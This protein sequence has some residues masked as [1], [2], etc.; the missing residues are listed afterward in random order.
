[1]ERRAGDGRPSGFRDGGVVHDRE[2]RPFKQ[3]LITSPPPSSRPQQR[4]DSSFA[5]STLVKY[6]GSFGARSSFGLKAQLVPALIGLGCRGT[7]VLELM[8]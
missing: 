4:A 1:M 2:P 8:L 3:Q 5:S 7:L 6:F